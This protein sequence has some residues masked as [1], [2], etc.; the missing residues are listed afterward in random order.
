MRGDDL[1]CRRSGSLCDDYESA[2]SGAQRS[3]L[4]GTSLLVGG[5]LLAGAAVVSWVL[6]PA[7]ATRVAPAVNKDSASVTLL[8]RF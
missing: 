6:W 3:A 4:L 5:G 8:G 1:S 7:P 2:R